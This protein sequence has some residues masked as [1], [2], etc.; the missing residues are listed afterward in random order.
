MIE[1]LLLA[2]FLG[3]TEYWVAT[4]STKAISEKHEWKAMGLAL[5][6]ILLWFYVISNYAVVPQDHL[7]EIAAYTAGAMIGVKSAF[8]FKKHEG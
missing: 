3:F 4:S 6:Q 8:G 1:K 7:P 5:A 2:G